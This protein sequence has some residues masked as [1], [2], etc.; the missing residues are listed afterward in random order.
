MVLVNGEPSDSISVFDRALQFG[1]G[2]FETIAIVNRKPCLWSL[3]YQRLIAGCNRLGIK[4]PT[5]DELQLDI[6]HLINND[7]PQIAKILVTRG[8]SSRGYQFPP[9]ILPNRIC[10]LSEW[11]RDSLTPP[12][13]ITLQTCKTRLGSQPMLAGLKHNGRLEQVLARNELGSSDVYSEGLLLDAN[14]RVIEAIA[15]NVFVERK[16]QLITP[17]LDSAGVAGVVRE[18]VIATGHEYQAEITENDL[19]VEDIRSADR[20][21]LTSSVLG[22]APVAQ[23]EDRNWVSERALHPVM[24]AAANRVFQ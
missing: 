2:L 16:G 11:P 4:P 19:Y 24:E 3:H 10:Y 9:N 6:A 15:A 18:L 1:D 13:G 8:N 12:S 21:Y 17:V 5:E 22:V 7:Q 23:F 20:I 14:D